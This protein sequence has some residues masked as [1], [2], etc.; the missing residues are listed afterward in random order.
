MGP[1]NKPAVFISCKDVIT[2]ETN[3]CY[4][5]MVVSEIDEE[6]KIEKNRINPATGP[7]YVNG[8]EPGDTLVVEIMN[9]TVKGN[10]VMRISPEFGVLKE[11]V[12]KSMF[13]LISISEGMINFN[14]KFKLPVK[15][16]IGVI[17][18][19]PAADN[20]GN[21]SPGDHGGNMDTRDICQG[22]IVYLPV[23]V[24]GGLL[25]L[26]DIH[27]LMGDGETSG[28]GVEVSGEVSIRVDVI[29]DTKQVRPY[30]ETENAYYTVCSAPTLEEASKFAV[31]DAVEM[32]MNKMNI[33]FEDAYMLVSLTCNLI[34]SQVVD[35]LMTVR[36]EIPKSLMGL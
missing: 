3:D 16:M 35:P 28:T 14:E 36:M 9:I 7:I 1:S 17:G 34:I 15:P 30:I 8:A 19:S 2:V 33:S 32:M 5:G 10:G 24:E 22:S 25:A 27:A 18:T 6:N 11:K 13:K 4:D 23:K 26:G 20:I 12:K 21:E 31:N 29:K